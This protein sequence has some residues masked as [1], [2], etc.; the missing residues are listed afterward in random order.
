MRCPQL[1][2]L[3]CFQLTIS[4]SQNLKK[5][6]FVLQYRSDFYSVL[7]RM[8][9]KKWVKSHYFQIFS[10]TVLS[11]FVCETC[12]LHHF[13]FLVWLPTRL[14]KSPITRFLPPKSHFLTTILPF[15][16][17]YFMVYEGFIYTIAAYVYAFCLAFSG[18]L[19]CILHHFT[20][21]LAPKRIAFS[22]KTHCVQ[23]QNALHLASKRTTFS[24]KQP[25]NWCK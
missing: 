17:M 6:I 15:S 10:F 1:I 19:P 13:T 23:H 20:L 11:V 8:L 2:N 12:I 21:R 22:T 5:V 7:A 4:S 18:T 14:F 25:K 9:V 16:T 3:Q 24:N